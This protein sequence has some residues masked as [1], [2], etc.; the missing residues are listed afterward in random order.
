MALQDLTPQLRTRLSR[1]E[2]AV[3]WFVFLAT[4]LLIFGFAYY[5]YHTAMRKGWFTPKLKY[6]TSLN[7]AAGL[8]VGDPVLLMGFS[9]GQI[10]GITP[11]APDAWYGVT[12]N[13]SVLKPHYG[14]IWDDSKVKV[15]SDLL[16]NRQLE[17][18]KGLAGVATVTE[19][20][21]HVAE[22]MLRWTAIRDARKKV[23]ADVT[24]ANPDLSRIN[25]TKF[26]WLVMDEL[27]RT[28]EADPGEF[29][30]NLN[31]TYWIPP[32]ESVA[33]NDRLE[34]IVS[35]V[36]Q[37]LPNI[38][39]LTN[40][41]QSVLANGSS[42]VSN[43]DTLAIAAQPVV[44]NLNL[45]SAQLR[46]PGGLG[47]WALGTNGAVQLNTTITDADTN[48][49]RLVE[50][51]ALSLDHLADITSNLNTQVQSNTNILGSVSKAVVDADDLVQGLKRV[52]FL[53][54]AFKTKDTNAP[55]ATS[56]PVLPPRMQQ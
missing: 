27:K 28:V 7:N 17:I 12:V 46:N 22:A 5:V 29:Y 40:Q 4:A 42:A 37:A 53:R 15:T 38:L 31:E 24:A 21:N 47:N 48:M 9:A 26:D 19:T 41:L 6:Q 16:G 44:A 2:R 32:V 43:L 18:T 51:L 8:K 30:T 35:L 13:F 23:L 36:E 25:Q 1:M 49:N 45:I 11:N 56:A 20:T 34:K 54:S 55:A 39:A 3:G 52:W 33:L 14:Y 10:T 50:G